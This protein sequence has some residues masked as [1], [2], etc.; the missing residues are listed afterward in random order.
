MTETRTPAQRSSDESAHTRHVRAARYFGRPTPDEK[1]QLTLERGQRLG[2]RHTPLTEQDMAVVAQ[3]GQTATT[4]GIWSD[5]APD[6]A[7]TLDLNT[8]TP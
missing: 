5:E 8:E 3:L 4:S 2:T 6:G 1:F 7:D